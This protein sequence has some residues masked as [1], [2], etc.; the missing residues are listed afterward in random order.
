MKKMLLFSVVLA[1]AL[2]CS[3]LISIRETLGEDNAW[4]A[5]IGA[6]GWGIIFLV[7]LKDF[8]LYL[9]SGK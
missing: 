4:V 8:I 6:I 1:S 2:V 3:Y 5:D 7:D 9:K